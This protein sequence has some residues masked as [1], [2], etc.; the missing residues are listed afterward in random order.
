MQ[1]PLSSLS[2]SSSILTRASL[3]ASINQA[4]RPLA[5]VPRLAVQAA[6]LRSMK[7]FSF[8]SGPKKAK[9]QPPPLP[10]YKFTAKVSG[11][12]PSL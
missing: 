5:C 11:F 4:P 3:L 2:R 8:D 9:D 12:F 6:L 10:V 7:P 1:L